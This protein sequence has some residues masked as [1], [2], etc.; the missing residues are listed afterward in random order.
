MKVCIVCH[1]DVSGKK[2]VKVREDNIIRFI[3]KIKRF[4]RIAKNNELY[5]CEEHIKEHK[6]RRKAFEKSMLF[7][8]VIAAIIILVFGG[9]LILSGRFDPGSFIS[10]LILGVIL[11]S[12]SVIF[13]FVPAVESSNPV[14]VGKRKKKRG[15]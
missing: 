13:K 14:R 1:E 2:A 4:L 15:D 12:F 7:F 5:V 6:K 9:L 11:I 10:L 3:R 8:G